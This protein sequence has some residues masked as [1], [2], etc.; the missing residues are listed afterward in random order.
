MLFIGRKTMKF[1]FYNLATKSFWD[2]TGAAVSWVCAAH[3]LAIPLLVSFFPL[4][5]ISFLVHEGLEYIFIALSIV[6]ALVSLLPS[7]FNNHR[8]I[9]ALLLFATGIVF[10]IFADILFEASLAGKIVFVLFGASCITM[11]HFINRRLCI[12]C[13]RC[14][15]NECRSSA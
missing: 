2:K 14:A 6:I 15:Q 7:Y 9:R 4:L 8:K 11:A 5:G 13:H 10:V 3:C 12:S 1:N